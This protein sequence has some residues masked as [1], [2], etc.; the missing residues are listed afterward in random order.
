MEFEGYNI[1]ET[2]T[3]T[4][5]I[6]AITSI[7]GVINCVPELM[8]DNGEYYRFGKIINQPN[9]VAYLNNIEIV[10]RED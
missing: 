3:E 9:Q 4:E 5:I 1:G 6:S 8:G 7:D 10:F 2:V